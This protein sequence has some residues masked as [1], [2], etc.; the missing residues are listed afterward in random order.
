M[1]LWTLLL[2]LLLLTILL[3]FPKSSLI[4][5][6]NSCLGLS[7]SLFRSGFTELCVFLISPC[8]LRDRMLSFISLIVSHSS[9]WCCVSDQGGVHLQEI[10]PF[11]GCDVTRYLY[12]ASRSSLRAG[13]TF[14]AHTKQVV[15][16]VTC[17]LRYATILAGN[18]V[19]RRFNI[20]M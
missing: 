10:A 5:C 19:N 9:M 1:E 15:N 2:F 11:L 18:N 7:S 17:V 13:I 8:A 20:I 6:S 4:L 16:I 14:H 3:S 12:T